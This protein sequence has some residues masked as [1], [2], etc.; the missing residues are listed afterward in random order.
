LKKKAE[1]KKVRFQSPEKENK[2]KE[3]TVEC[4]NKE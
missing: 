2:K 3:E 1:E 4:E